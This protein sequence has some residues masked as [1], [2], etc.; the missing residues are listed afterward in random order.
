VGRYSQD[1]KNIEALDITEEDKRMI[2]GE[3][4]VK[5]FHIEYWKKK[6]VMRRY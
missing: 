5:L 6:I 1:H 2:P 3:N 4:A